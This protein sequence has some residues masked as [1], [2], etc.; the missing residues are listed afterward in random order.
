MQGRSIGLHNQTPSPN[1]TPYFP[2][3]ESQGGWRWFQSPEDVRTHARMDAHKL[4]QLFELQSFLFGSESWGTVIIR[5]G[6]LVRE[7][8]SFMGLATSR[9]DIW[10]CTKSFTGTA[11]G[12]LLD[13]SQRGRLPDGLQVNLDTPAYSLLPTELPL[14]DP[15][16]E[17]ITIG[18]LL[19]MTSG[20]PGEAMGLYG[21]PTATGSG[22]F[23]H[24]LGYG[25]NR[26][27]KWTNTLT[28]DPGTHWDYSDPAMAHL[29]LLF[30]TVAQQDMHEYMQRRIFDPI[31]IEEASWDVLG[32]GGFMGPHTNPHV[33]LHISAREMARFGY[34]LLRR[35]IWLG[36]QLIP[37]W[38]LDLATRSSQ[39]L[40]PEYGYTFWVNTE[41]TRWPGLPTD[42]FALEGYKCNRCY[43]IPSLDLVVVRVGSGP[44]R[45]NEPDFIGGVVNAIISD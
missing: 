39:T 27:G 26:Y 21:V 20:I 5:K 43:V 40:N 23:E 34:L 7:H 32:G 38:W 4:D 9:F 25:A 33:G 1:S 18:H 3:P 29:S 16:K 35:G 15:R 42:M 6:Y 2:P 8:Y 12:L 30:S 19:T 28:A 36:K 37:Q 45:W 14:S 10:S 31:G 13:D 24:A 44:P 11:W 17:A 22:P 41:G